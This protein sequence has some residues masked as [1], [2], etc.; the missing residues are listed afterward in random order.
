MYPAD[1]L[2]ALA[3]GLTE[4]AGAAPDWCIFD[5]TALGAAEED[6]LAIWATGIDFLT[7]G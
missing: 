6:A 5:N 3:E 2:D 4:S 1:A 7:E